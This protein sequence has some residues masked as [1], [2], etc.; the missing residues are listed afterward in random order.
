MN[1]DKVTYET[2]GT[3]Q[4][5]YTYDSDGKL[6]SMNLN[7]TEYYYIKNAQDDIIGLIDKA[8]T[9]VTSY[10]YDTYGK[11]ISIDGSLKDTA[12][13]IN[14]YRYREYRYDSETGL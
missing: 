13:K 5:Y 7:D 3:N 12:H 10:T 6:L 9:Q 2:D 8:G 4:I 14:T 1:S 11:V